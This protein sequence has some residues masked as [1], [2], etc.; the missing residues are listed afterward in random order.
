M[1][2][3]TKVGNKV[4]GT[5]GKEYTKVGNAVY[6]NRGGKQYTKVGNMVYGPIGSDDDSEAIVPVGILFDEEDE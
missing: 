5:N 6:S 4:Y 1:S 2:S 3:W